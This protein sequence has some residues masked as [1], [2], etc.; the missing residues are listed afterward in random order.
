M[1]D[2][3]PEEISILA[4]GPFKVAQQF[5][6]YTRNGLHFHTQSYDDGRPVQNSG[7]ALVAQTTR[8]EKGNAD[9]MI[10]GNQTFYGIIKE[11]LELNYENKGKIVL[12][13]CDWV[14]NRRKDKWVKVDRLGVTS[15]NFKHLVNTGENISD[16]PFVLAS[17]A[18]QVFYVED[19][20]D[21]EWVTVSHYNPRG[22]YAMHEAEDEDV[23]TA[24]PMVDPHIYSCFHDDLQ[25][26]DCART[27][28]DGRIVY[29]KK[30]RK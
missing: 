21:D 26:I 7:V 30:S 3:V 12:F 2:K 16:E 29:A 15:M 8:Y 23:E 14:D 24:M 17:Q 20:I 28:I 6:S 10:I 18:T 19:P 22:S 1:G 25:S 5:S 27:D 4:Q 13:K 11:I 9:N